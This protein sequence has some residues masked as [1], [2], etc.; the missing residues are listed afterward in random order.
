VVRYEV[1]VLLDGRRCEMTNK[2]RVRGVRRKRID[3]ERL[4][5][6]F[7]LLAKALIEESAGPA[8]AEQDAD[9]EAA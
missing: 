2:V 9:S 1:I 3:D 6:A 4:A 8:G 5:Y 7:L